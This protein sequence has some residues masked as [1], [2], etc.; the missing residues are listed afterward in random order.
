MPIS[1]TKLGWMNNSPPAINAANLGAMDDALKSVID[2]ANTIEAGADVTATA[3][4]TAIKGG[5][6]T[7][8]PA[9]TDV[10]PGIDSGNARRFYTWANIKSALGAVFAPLTHAS[11]HQHGGADEIA[12]ATP[13]AN[14][15]PK[16]DG[17]GKL[18]SWV[19]D[20]TTSTKGKVQLATDGNTDAGKAVQ[21]ND[22]RLPI[23]GTFTPTVIAISGGEATYTTQYGQYV[24]IGK[25][26]HVDIHLNF[27]KNT[28]S[29]GIRISGLPYTPKSAT[30]YRACANISYHQ[31]IN[32]NA[33]YQNIGG[34]VTYGAPY[35][36]LVQNS[37]TYNAALITDTN[38][39]A[40]SVIIVSA[41]YVID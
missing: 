2:H 7:T 30:L 20:A 35:I 5:T 21:A 9:D 22:S 29:G 33:N 36:I 4:P 10:V 6:A 24:K 32:V 15:I 27:N 14:A 13:T 23:V 34:Y 1:Y 26:V 31:G 3:L 38:L 41:D 25:L 11:R 37:F 12:T 8:T 19:S 18:D 16:A 28:L 39:S 17:I 40:S